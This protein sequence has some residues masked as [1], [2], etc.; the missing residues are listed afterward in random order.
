MSLFIVPLFFLLFH[1][2]QHWMKDRN[3]K[4][5]SLVKRSVQLIGVNTLQIYVLQY[6][7]FRL[8]DYLSNNTL[9]QFTLNNEWLMSPV[10]ALAHCYFC[11]L[12]TILINK[13]KLG[14]VF[15]R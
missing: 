13:L 2:L 15:G 4:V 3:S 5:K 6:F 10:I 11:V 9:S 8:F 7:S 12:V 14:F 1:E